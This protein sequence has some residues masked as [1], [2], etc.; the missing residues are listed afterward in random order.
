MLIK[1]FFRLAIKSLSSCFIPILKLGISFWDFK[2][3]DLIVYWFVSHLI[4]P[5]ATSFSKVPKLDQ[6]LKHYIILCIV[7]KTNQK[8]ICDK[9]HL[10]RVENVIT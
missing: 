6:H 7:L 3:I 9:V 2:L 5:K 4:A 1:G 10:Y 8:S